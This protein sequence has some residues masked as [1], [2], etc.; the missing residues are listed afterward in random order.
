MYS[1]RSKDIQSISNYK[2][3]QITYECIKPIRGDCNDIRPLAARKHKHLRIEKFEENGETLY[4]A[5][6]Y[7]TRCVTW[8]PDGRMR[9]SHGGWPSQT[10]AG[11]LYEVLPFGMTPRL[12]SRS[13][14]LHITTPGVTAGHYLISSD[15]LLL[16]ADRNPVNPVRENKYTSSRAK[17][18]AVMSRF[19]DFLTWAKG[20]ISLTEGVVEIKDVDPE[21]KLEA[22]HIERPFPLYRVNTTN[23]SANVNARAKLLA[24]ITNTDAD[25]KYECYLYAIRVFAFSNGQMKY[26][27]MTG[28]TPTYALKI[29]LDAIKKKLMQLHAPEV[30]V[31]TLAEANEVVKRHPLQSWAQGWVSEAYKTDNK[32][33]NT[34]TTRTT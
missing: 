20:Y 28:L 14:Y 10:T 2:A 1:Y 11:F 4:A 33:A 9:I 18:N 12:I 23:F 21:Q 25:S 15:G 24:L 13:L 16:D 17:T 31:E 27:S 29:S 3:A 19:K 6:L 5:V 32:E 26:S 22:E 7:R 30:L 8:Y 34:Q